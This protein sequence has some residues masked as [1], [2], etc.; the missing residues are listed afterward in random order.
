MSVGVL[1]VGVGGYGQNYLDEVLDRPNE[2]VYHVAGIC[3]P[4]L[5][6][7]PRSADVISRQ[8]PLFSDYGEA[9][10]SADVN[11]VVISSP[12]HTHY[13]Y[14]KAALQAG[15]MVLCEK[16]VTLEEKEL[17]DLLE[18]E[19][20]SSG[21]VAV[22][23]QQCY[24]ND[25]SALK[26]DISRGMY[27]K[28]LLLKSLHMMR[29]GMT[30]Y[31]RNSWAGKIS[32]HG[33]E[34]FDSPLSNAC[35]HDVENMLYLLGKERT[36]TAVVKSVDA[37]RFKGNPHI[38]NF[39]AVA[40]SVVTEENVPLLFYTAHSIAEKRVGPYNEYRFENGTIRLVD[41]SYVAYGPDGAVLRDYR[42]LGEGDRMEKFFAAIRM[43]SDGTEPACR[44]CTAYEHMRLVRLAQGPAMRME[45]E[46]V[47][48]DGQECYPIPHLTDVFAHCYETESLPDE[49]MIE[50]GTSTR[51]LV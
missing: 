33:M 9:L 25:V 44:L 12:I 50:K 5:S 1:L 18:T 21:V 42:P 13:G 46:P 37:R 20:N 19:R 6:S 30:Y 39:D 4:F 7:S 45:A 29:R 8:F 24:R 51:R 17:D 47:M 10:A 15:K 48:L 38:E 26:E 31:R 23:F 28:P 43:A 35:A 34:I 27:G 14:V 32:V 22:G 16:P 40:L 3:D 49:A 36:E 11:L 2:D 41:G